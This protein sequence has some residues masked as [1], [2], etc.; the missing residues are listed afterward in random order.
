VKAVIL[1]AG[2]SSRLYPLTL[3]MPKCLLPLEG[4]IAIIDYQISILKEN[5]INDI[6]VVIGYKKELIV[7]HLKNKDINFKV[8]SDYENYNNMHTLYSIKEILI[9]D[10]IILFSDVL[11]HSNLL[12]KLINNHDYSLLV[13]N[14]SVLKDT[15]RVI[16][17]RGI[18][19]GIGS[20][21]SVESG[22]G[23]FVGVAK[24]SKTGVNI[25]INEISKLILKPE[26]DQA[27]YTHPLNFISKYRD[28]KLVNANHSPWIEVDFLKDYRRARSTVYPKIKKVKE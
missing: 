5:N 7:E 21:I 23:N 17:D 20:H 3:K 6:T 8:F 22:N 9:D 12:K 24:F 27:Y 2:K 11:I 16:A 19:K 15:M 10:V 18:I 28:I 26:F 4:G 14:K 25:L 1:A 13:H